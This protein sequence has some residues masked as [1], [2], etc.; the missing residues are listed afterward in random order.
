MD[1]IVVYIH[2]QNGSIEEAKHYKPLFSDCE[3][4]GFDY[5]AQTPWEAKDEF[6]K[7]FNSRKFANKSIIIIA[8]SIGAYFLMNMMPSRNIEKA[9]LISPIVDMENL[10]IGMMKDAKVSEKE[11]CEK[12]EIKLLS[13]QILS[14]EYLTYVREHSIEWE[15]I[16]HILYGKKDNLMPFDVISRFSKKIG[17]TL[18]IMENGEHWFHTDEEMKFLD[19]W[20]KKYVF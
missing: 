5:K 19:N 1:K 6:T 15:V 2:G 16:T 9:F 8:N 10:I 13:G 12:K 20:I 18:T 11:L 4:I 14:W 7:Y 3:V 17:A